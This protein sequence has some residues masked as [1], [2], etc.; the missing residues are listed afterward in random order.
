V[1]V[2]D[3]KQVAAAASDPPVE[4]IDHTPGASPPPTLDYVPADLANRDTLR[5]AGDTTVSDRTRR[6][7]GMARIG[8]YEIDG[9]LGRGGMGVVYRARHSKLG[10]L[11]AIKMILAGPHADEAAL[12]RFRVEGQAVARL[13]H[14]G[15]VQI[16]ELGEHDGLAYFVLEYV[17][18][19]SLLQ[20]IVKELPTPAEA[21][22]LVEQLSR[23]MQHAHDQGILHRDLKPA[24]VLLTPAG[25]PKV[26]DFGLAKSL[27]TDSAATASGTVLGTPSYMSPEQARGVVSELTPATDQYSLGAILYHLL[28]G[29]APFVAANPVD[30]LLQVM[31]EE[32]VAPRQLSPKTPA[33]LETICLKALAKEP[34]RRYGSCR[35]LAD[36]LARFQAN[37]PIVARSVSRTERLW[38]WCR[39]NP[40]IAIP[41]AASV[42]LFLLAFA[43]M[44]ISSVVLSNLNS[45]LQAQTTAAQNAKTLAEKETERANQERNTANE[46][47]QLAD[48]RADVLIQAAGDNFREIDKQIGR[49][50]H[51]QPLKREIVLTT[52]RSL[53]KLPKM[54]GKSGRSTSA[55]MLVFHKLM[56]QM[57]LEIGQTDKAW[58]HVRQ[59]HEIARQR[60][61]DQDNSTASRSNLAAI[62]KDMAQIR[63]KFDR[64]M[65]AAITYALEAVALYEDILAHP[66]P[67]PGDPPRLQIA[68]F[69][70]EAHLL[71]AAFNMRLGH[72]P[73]ALRHFELTKSVRESILTDPVYLKLPEKTRSQN[74]AVFRQKSVTPLAGIGEMQFRMENHDSARTN[75]DEALKIREEYPIAKKSL[76]DMLSQTGSFYARIGESQQAED[77]LRRAVKLAGEL[78]AADPTMV[79]YQAGLALA[80]FRLGA[81][82]AAQGD[83]TAKESFEACLKIRTELAKDESNVDRQ[84]ELL[85]VLPRAGR[86]REAAAQAEKVLKL[87]PKPDI[88]ILLDLARAAA[89]SSVAAADDPA[90]AGEYRKQA[91]AHLEKV[92]HAGHRDP[93]YLETEPDFISL[94]NDDQFRAL[95]KRERDLLR[96][97]ATAAQ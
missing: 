60:I 43:A 5:L 40:R 55:T 16:Y 82:L 79:D 39:R 21:A 65:D 12:A 56:Y 15:I 76:A 54:T 17:A 11:V 13:Q 75:Y 74:A 52:A 50:P 7:A 49:T 28:T 26:S 41:T 85:L 61:V 59:A 84:R 22:R 35:E 63:L 57:Y 3:P 8:D 37:E 44:A 78:A 47:R 42:Q 19:K 24:N 64:D 68:D 27:E 90:A 29:R 66:R 38:R 62:C 93:H 1:T 97:G 34:A 91:L 48:D 14:P 94:W 2:S 80:H 53:E 77:R 71:V 51:L 95:V 46:A 9:E 33:D 89:T 30:T 18:G 31:H 92:V 25:D 87:V 83:A 10:R 86:H 73:E 70:A 20:R 45:K 36:D 67:Q 4:T 32:P 72:P 23:T 96:G 69:L 58:E 88:E 6:P 81:L